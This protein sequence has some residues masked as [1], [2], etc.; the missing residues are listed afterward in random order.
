MANESKNKTGKIVKTTRYA[1]SK[2]NKPGVATVD[3]LRAFVVLCEAAGIPGDAEVKLQSP[4]EQFL[5]HLTPIDR[6]EAVWS[7]EEEQ[8]A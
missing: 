4:S 8:E 7:I 5:G 1:Q 6:L 2:L 3:E